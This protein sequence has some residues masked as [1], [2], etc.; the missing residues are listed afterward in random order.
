[1][2]KN[3]EEKLCVIKKITLKVGDKEITLTP[4]EARALHDSLAEIYAKETQYLPITTQIIERERPFRQWW[5]RPL[6]PWYGVN[7]QT[8]DSLKYEQKAVDLGPSL[9][10]TCLTEEVKK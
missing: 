2:S 1:M 3:K 9:R 8:G 5:D 4:Q 6:T 7:T 10:M